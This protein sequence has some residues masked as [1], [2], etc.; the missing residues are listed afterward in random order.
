[1]ARKEP[2]KREIDAVKAKFHREFVRFMALSDAEKT[3]EAE[4]AA[5]TPSKPLTPAER[6]MCDEMGIGSAG[7]RSKEVLI[8]ANRLP[9]KLAH[10]KKRRGLRGDPEEL[11]HWDW[12]RQPLRKNPAKDRG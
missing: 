12:W 9:S 8:V 7:R 5:R 10:L 6:A 3:R 4:K 11:V 1:M 2:T